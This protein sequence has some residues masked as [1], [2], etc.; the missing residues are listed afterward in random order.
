[1][2]RIEEVIFEAMN[3]G[4]KDQVFNRVKRMINS[5]KYKHTELN[6]IYEKALR[7]EKKFLFENNP[8]NEQNQYPHQ[9]KI[10]G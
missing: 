8:L 1:M 3:L 10:K 9:D 2:S 6:F 5:D 4:L 7:K